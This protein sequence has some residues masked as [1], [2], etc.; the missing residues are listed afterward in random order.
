MLRLYCKHCHSKIT[1]Y[2]FYQIYQE[3]KDDYLLRKTK[4]IPQTPFS[5]CF[6]YFL[7]M[8]LR[9]GRRIIL[10]MHFFK[11][12]SSSR[13]GPDQ[14]LGAGEGHMKESFSFSLEAAS[15]PDLVTWKC[16]WVSIYFCLWGDPSG[17]WPFCHRYTSW[18]KGQDRVDK[19]WVHASCWLTR[20][21]SQD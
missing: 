7:K 16:R 5:Y 19:R 9:S 4:N 1:V 3:N 21:Y 20:Y 14:T 2:I 6:F 13:A 8:L 11:C 12:I 15:K 10:F 18:G 17:S